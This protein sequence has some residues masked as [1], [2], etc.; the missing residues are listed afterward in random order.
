MDR[1]DLAPSMP[2]WFTYPLLGLLGLQIAYII[3]RTPNRAA[4]YLIVVFW[5]RFA[6]D[7]LHAVT[8]REVALGLSWIA[9]SSVASVL[10]GLVVLDRRRFFNWAFLPVAAICLLMIVSAILN[11]RIATA[12]EPLLRMIFF[13]VLTVATWQALEQSGPKVLARLGWTFAIPLIFQA[14]SVLLG[15]VKSGESDGSAS[16]IGGFNHEQHFSLILVA[17]FYVVVYGRF[18]RPMWKVPLAIAALVGLYL[19]NY[20][21]AMI[22]VIPLMLASIALAVPAVFP[23]QQRGAVRTVVLI[24][25]ATLFLGGAAAE[26]DRFGDLATI[27]ENPGQI[28]R[29]PQEFTVDDKRLL[30]GRAY[31][32]S[33]YIDAYRGGSPL[34]H[35]IGFGP[36]AW[37][38]YFGIYAH[39]TLISYLYEL[40]WIGVIAILSLWIS[41][42]VLAFRTP[43][44]VRPMLVTG[45]VSFILLNMAT[46]PHWQIEGNMLYAILC[47]YTLYTGQRRPKA[48]RIRQAIPTSQTTAP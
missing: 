1:V 39:N 33:N 12:I 15:V 46:M 7:A 25:S 22:G 3:L 9:L 20:R 34:Q 35:V 13:A 44:E 36:D 2:A 40:G 27:V 21:T 19:A 43:R 45:H 41:M 47:G 14:G 4:R 30:S 17:C 48:G 5:I 42:M 24:L 38:D 16:Y 37:S 32:W 10:L 23:K 18:A 29:P 31:I 6:M 26:A 28:I 11:Q 8:F